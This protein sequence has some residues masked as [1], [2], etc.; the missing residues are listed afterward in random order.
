M[1]GGVFFGKSQNLEDIKALEIKL[2]VYLKDRGGSEVDYEIYQLI[3]FAVR[4]MA[5]YSRSFDSQCA[6]N[7]A[8]IGEKFIE[9]VRGFSF[10]SRAGVE[11]TFS[12][13]YR[14]LMEYQITSPDEGAD[15]LRTV[16]YNTDYGSL[17]LTPSVASQIRYA[18]HQMVVG[19]IK[20]YLHHP[21][22]VDLKELPA[23]LKKARTEQDQFKKD[24]TQR[25]VKVDELKGALDNYQ[26]AFN[27][28]GLHKGFGEL[29]ERKE[30][31]KERG[32]FLMGVLVVLML[33]PFIVKFLNI[34]FA[35]GLV[36]VSLDSYVLLVGFELLLMYF[37]RI[38]LHNFK[39]VQ[40][41]L[42]Q[43]DLRMTLC[44][45][46]QSY[47]KYAKEIKSGDAD[48]LLRFEQVVFSGIVNSDDAIPS[49]FDG[50]DQLSKIISSFKKS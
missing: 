39:S 6:F 9:E 28:V 46:I 25:K 16:L 42:L 14:F 48:L 20:S 3:Y 44:Q 15:E 27:F 4:H 1:V 13:C 33:L 49:S 41:Q 8:N 11:I 18:G 30:K 35:D 19:V 5:K 38:V 40:A 23:L 34:L 21:E 2:E 12:C 31:E 32:V 36:V 29:K 10:E 37:F 26:D 45:F 50:L 43:V 22:M 17:N 24:Y 47:T 7:I